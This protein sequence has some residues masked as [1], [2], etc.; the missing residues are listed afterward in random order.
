MRTGESLAFLGSELLTGEAGGSFMEFA[1]VG[2]LV[3][4]FCTLLLLAW[5]RNT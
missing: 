5:Y 2:A 1:L 3:L 4:V